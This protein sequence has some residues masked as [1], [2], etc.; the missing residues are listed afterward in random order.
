M[1]LRDVTTGARTLFLHVEVLQHG[2]THYVVFGDADSL[3]PPMRVD[4]CSEVAVTF[5]Q[6]GCPAHTCIAHAHR[7]VPYAW[8]EPTW[9]TR[10]VVT[11]PGGVS[12]TYDVDRLGRGQQLTYENFIY[13]AFTGTFDTCV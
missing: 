4:N 12:S 1:I 6:A 2:A 11:A 5:A 9:P 13:V 8:D 7:S 10:L 3:P